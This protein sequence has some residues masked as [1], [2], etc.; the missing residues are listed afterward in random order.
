MILPCVYTLV[1]T[2]LTFLTGQLELGNS[3][4]IRRVTGVLANLIRRW[5][6]HTRV[7]AYS[8]SL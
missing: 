2:W 6:T 1:D 7:H 4:R 5:Y 8:T 3:V